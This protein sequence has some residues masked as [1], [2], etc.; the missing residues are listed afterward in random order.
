[1]TVEPLNLVAGHVI[2]D[3]VRTRKWIQTLGREHEVDS[4]RGPVLGG[5]LKAIVT[6]V[7]DAGPPWL[8]LTYPD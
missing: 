3:I 5:A 4:D 6:Q 8:W 1:M 2:L 7:H